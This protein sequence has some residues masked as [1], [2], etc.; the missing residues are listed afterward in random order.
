[1]KG[2]FSYNKNTDAPE[3]E[4]SSPPPIVKTSPD[5]A[6]MTKLLARRPAAPPPRSLADIAKHI[7]VG[8]QLAISANSSVQ[9]GYDKL[10][11]IGA[12]SRKPHAPELTKA[13]KTSFKGLR[14]HY[15]VLRRMLVSANANNMLSSIDKEF[16]DPYLEQLYASIYVG[17][18]SMRGAYKVVKKLNKRSFIGFAEPRAFLENT[19]VFNAAVADYSRALSRLKEILPRTPAGAPSAITKSVIQELATATRLPGD[20]DCPYLF[21]MDGVKDTAAGFSFGVSRTI[22]MTSNEQQLAGFL[23]DVANNKLSIGFSPWDADY[24]AVILTYIWK[25]AFPGAIETLPISEGL[26]N[27]LA[28]GK[29]PSA[30]T[31]A[32][33]TQ[34]MMVS[35][36]LRLMF[37]MKDPAIQ[38]FGRFV[39]QTVLRTVKRY[40]ANVMLFHWPEAIES[41]QKGKTENLFGSS[42]WTF[43]QYLHYIRPYD[44]GDLDFDTNLL[45]GPYPPLRSVYANGRPRVSG[46][47]VDPALF[48]AAVAKA[49][50]IITP[51]ADRIGKQNAEAAAKLLSDRLG[52]KLGDKKIWKAI[53]QPDAGGIKSSKEFVDAL[54]IYKDVTGA[55]DA[56]AAAGK[57]SQEYTALN[58]TAEVI[59][60]SLLAWAIPNAGKGGAERAFVNETK[61]QLKSEA[62]R[63]R[64]PLKMIQAGPRITRSHYA[65]EAYDEAFH[66]DEDMPD[67]EDTIEAY[68][69][70]L[71]EL[72]AAN[73]QLE[74]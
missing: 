51:L 44:G 41:L 34:L 24:I 57:G 26:Q 69:H 23:R 30:S 37:G 38:A 55:R 8:K 62:A 48:T 13:M 4:A 3:A 6:A 14:A 50:D 5:S 60:S 46:A 25:K 16:I 28:Q 22:P 11:Q 21:T 18:K 29:E 53:T 39:E 66:A 40:N 2:A 47:S 61:E 42:R 35:A 59:S 71:E 20:G 31:E 64:G 63:V 70:A 58:G 27:L 1:M 7:D 43:D 72:V 74:L 67:L 19:L 10:S 33:L 68:H 17:K 32:Y 49:A 52:K 15:K 54:A 45:R 36:E 65:G 56:L 73:Y 12:L 9:D